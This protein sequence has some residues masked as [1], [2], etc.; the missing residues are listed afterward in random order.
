M[1]GDEAEA[2]RRFQQ[3]ATLDPTFLTARRW[4][5]QSGM[6]AGMYE[7]DEAWARRADSLISGLRLLRDRL[8]PFDRARLDFV[9]ALRAGDLLERYRAELRLVDA[10]P[11]SIYARREMALSALEDLRPRE[12]QRRLY[13]RDIS[14]GLM[15]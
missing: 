8:A 14:D 10:A 5:A 11:G 4:T 15:P 13:M 2:A 12:A 9:V 1:A 7:M 3:A 6:L